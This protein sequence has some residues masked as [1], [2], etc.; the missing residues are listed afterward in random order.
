MMVMP[1][2]ALLLLIASLLLSLC[3]ARGCVKQRVFST[4]FE[5][6]LVCDGDAGGSQLSIFANYI[7]YKVLGGSGREP[8][9][10][11]VPLPNTL[12]LVIRRRS[13]GSIIQNASFIRVNGVKYVY[14]QSAAATSAYRRY[15]NALQVLVR[16]FE[17]G[18]CPI[19]NKGQAFPEL[20]SVRGS[21]LSLSSTF[22]VSD[23]SGGST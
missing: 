7:W 1:T 16:A 23:C 22:L 2:S 10:L 18:N 5:N 21:L 15:F 9:G 3:E 17:T 8:K 14:G 6:P 20:S 11:P 13:N 19:D 12:Q 4:G